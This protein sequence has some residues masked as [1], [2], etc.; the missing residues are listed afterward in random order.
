MVFRGLIEERAR[1]L[2]EEAGEDPDAVDWMG[3]PD[4]INGTYSWQKWREYTDEA[5]AQL[6]AEIAAEN[7]TQGTKEGE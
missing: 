6:K 5:E 1:Q 3:D 2:C 4:V 7:A